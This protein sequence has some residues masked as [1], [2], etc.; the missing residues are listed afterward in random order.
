MGR[1]NSIQTHFI[2]MNLQPINL[3]NLD[4]RVHDLEQRKP[5]A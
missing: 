2:A 1:N 3:G 5:D 4:T